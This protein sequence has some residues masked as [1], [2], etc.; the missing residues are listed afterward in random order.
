MQ[1]SSIRW[2][3]SGLRRSSWGTIDMYGERPY[4]GETVFVKTLLIIHSQ[5]LFCRYLIYGYIAR[6]GERR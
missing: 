5:F 3:I 4:L 2:R 6:I 1:Q